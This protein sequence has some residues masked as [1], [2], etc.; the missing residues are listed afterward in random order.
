[1]KGNAITLVGI[2]SRCKNNTSKDFNNKVVCKR[3]KKLL[4]TNCNYFKLNRNIVY[5]TN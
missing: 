5:I 2:C 4:V 1:M 3:H